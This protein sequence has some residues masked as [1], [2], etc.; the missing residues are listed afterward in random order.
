[1]TS[2]L[3]WPRCG[4]LDAMV[5]FLNVNKCLSISYDVFISLKIEPSQSPSES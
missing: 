5:T 4:H 3:G 1:M 2:A